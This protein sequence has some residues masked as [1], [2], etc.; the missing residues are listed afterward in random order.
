MG[1][2]FDPVGGGQF[3]EAVRQIIEAEKKPIKAIEERKA[4]D[5][6][7][8]KLFQDF[9]S[10]FAGVDKALAEISTFNK[11]REFKVDLG[12]GAN[13]IG[14]T[15]DKEKCQPGTYSIEVE[16]LAKRTAS[17]PC[18][19]AAMTRRVAVASSAG[20]NLGSM[21]IGMPR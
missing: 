13:S 4:R 2:R 14:V 5:E 7:K 6:A 12:D 10:R 11:F 16:S 9:K 18:C 1:L 19:T 3:K 8:L 17:R 15:V 20:K 21:V